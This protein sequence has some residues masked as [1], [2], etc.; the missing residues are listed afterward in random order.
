MFTKNQILAEIKRT[1]EEN[2]GKALGVKAFGTETGIQQH[3]WRG[4]FWARWSDALAEAGFGAN[5]WVGA[6]PDNELLERLA[7]L[8]REI[9]RFPTISEVRLKRRADP[10]F[11]SDTAYRRFGGQRALA[12]RVREY[13]AARGEHDIA[14]LC[15]PVADAEVAEAID[16]VSGSRGPDGFV[17]MIRSGRF[18]KIGRTNAVGRRERE[19]EIQLPERARLVHSI[20]TDDPVGIEAYWHGRFADRRKNGE[21]FELTGADIAA[22]KRRKFM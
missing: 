6:Y 22:F 4:R 15:G 11:P 18:H 17:Y 10:T 19:L 21:W 16:T 14:A 20:K 8:A 13:S 2:G 1:A 9:G 7:A 3:D 12:A 5:E